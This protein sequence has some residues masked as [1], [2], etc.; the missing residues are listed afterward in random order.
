MIQL[1]K[2]AIALQGLMNAAFAKG[3]K[4]LTIS[5]GRSLKR[6][7]RGRIREQLANGIHGLVCQLGDILTKTETGRPNLIWKALRWTPSFASKGKLLYSVLAALHIS[8]AY[9]FR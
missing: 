6:A 8:F 1:E 7:Q 2:M 4:D 3:C 9:Q 5:A